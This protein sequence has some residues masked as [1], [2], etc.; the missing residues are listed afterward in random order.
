MR[1]P[2]GYGVPGAGRGKLNCPPI[3]LRRSFDAP[4]P[5]TQFRLYGRAL[6]MAMMNRF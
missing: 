2:G 3:C 5:V 1:R 6:R 4:H